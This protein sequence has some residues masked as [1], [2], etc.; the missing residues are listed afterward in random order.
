[1][2]RLYLTNWFGSASRI[3]SLRSLIGS[4]RS[5][6]GRYALIGVSIEHEVSVAILKNN[7]QHCCTEIYFV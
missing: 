3:G 6:I 7:S 1:M 2:V 4:L 5:L